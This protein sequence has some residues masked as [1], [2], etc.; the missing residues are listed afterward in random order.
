MFKFL[1]Y[2]LLL[3]FFG[4]VALESAAQKGFVLGYKV[5]QGDTIYQIQ[6][7]E[8][9]V[10][11]RPTFKNEKDKREYRRLVHNFSKT[12]PYALL[13]KQRVQEMDSAITQIPSE[14]LRKQFIKQKE[15]DLFKE[16]EKP[17][18][19]LTFSQGR[20][21]MRLID[22]ELGQTS[23]Y[24]IK[25]LRGGFT[26]FF[27]QGVAKIFGADLKKPYDKYGEDKE[28]ET[29]VKMY[30]NGTFMQYYMQVFQN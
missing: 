15:K 14:A 5:E 29:L 4:I 22:R 3:S 11:P 17:L 1:K 13:A 10:S 23:Y 28:V 26:A 2:S 16:F 30:Q 18:K 8:L 21:L 6:M 7:N 25:D 19:K 12:Y 9:Y 20:L 27:W 24:L